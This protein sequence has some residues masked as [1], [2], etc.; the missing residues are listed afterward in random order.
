MEL[1]GCEDGDLVGL[2]SGDGE[3]GV[4]TLVRHLEVV[5]GDLGVLGAIEG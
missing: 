3:L 1:V 5:C 2:V 4:T